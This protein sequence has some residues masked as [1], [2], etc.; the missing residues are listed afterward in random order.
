MG[1][2]HVPEGEMVVANV[3]SKVANRRRVEGRRSAYNVP[4]TIVTGVRAANGDG[5]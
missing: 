3:R 2:V 5:S 1:S 4:G